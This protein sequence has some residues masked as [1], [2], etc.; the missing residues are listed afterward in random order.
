MGCAHYTKKLTIYKE[1][2]TFIFISEK[3]K[4]EWMIMEEMIQYWIK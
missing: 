2:C 1:A 3:A 4:F